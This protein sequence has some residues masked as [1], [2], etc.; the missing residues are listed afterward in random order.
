MKNSEKSL[1]DIM[2]TKFSDVLLGCHKDLNGFLRKYFERLFKGKKVV[3]IEKVD[4]SE[5]IKILGFRNNISSWRDPNGNP[6]VSTCIIVDGI[7][8]RYDYIFILGGELADVEVEDKVSIVADSTIVPEQ[9]KEEQSSKP[10]EEK[11]YIDEDKR[12]EIVDNIEKIF[13]DSFRLKHSFQFELA[14]IKID[15]MIELLIER[16]LQEYAKKLEEKRNYLRMAQ[17]IYDNRH[18]EF[19]Q[20]NERMKE[21][22]QAN[23]V[24]KNGTQ[25]QEAIS[26]VN[27]MIKEIRGKEI[28]GYLQILEDKKKELTTA[29]EI[30]DKQKKEISKQQEEQIR[31]F[32]QEEENIKTLKDLE[33]MLRINKSYNQFEAAKVNIER[34][35]KILNSMNRK[36]IT[37]KYQ[38]ELKE[39]KERFDYIEDVL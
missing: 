22:T 12:K 39:I 37:E 18:E 19:N 27:A 25:F 2:F 14:I 11:P 38:A 26:N 32:S 8:K 17:E 30:Y 13:S 35:I 10:L 28:P 4:S 36:D 21:L 16:N 31:D 6:I 3:K 7:Q 24:L 15:S 33:R 9:V 34:M 5:K 1:L 29:Q 20:L 23:I